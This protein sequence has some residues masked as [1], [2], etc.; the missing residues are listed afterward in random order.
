MRMDKYSPPLVAPPFVISFRCAQSVFGLKSFYIIVQGQSMA[1]HSIFFHLNGV[2]SLYSLDYIYLQNQQIINNNI[3]HIV[4]LIHI[5]C[6]SFHFYFLVQFN[7][8]RLFATK[9][10]HSYLLNEIDAAI[11]L[12]PTYQQVWKHEITENYSIC[13]I[14]VLTTIKRF[15]SFH[16]TNIYIQNVEEY[17]K[18]FSLELKIAPEFSTKSNGPKIIGCRLFMNQNAHFA[19][20]IAQWPPSSVTIQIFDFGIFG[21]LCRPLSRSSM[22]SFSCFVAVLALVLVFVL[23][24]CF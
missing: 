14:F 20:K 18:I 1:N 23:G 15:C 21:F 7:V 22:K 11:V 17:I 19:R 13:R 4:I 8:F 12:L 9:F 5:I 3:L 6:R 16:N 2:D 24:R 10:F